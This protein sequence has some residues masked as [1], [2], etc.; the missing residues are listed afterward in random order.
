MLKKCVMLILVL[1]VVSACATVPT[2]PSVMVLPAVGKPFDQF[3]LD[4]MVCRQYA[5]QQVG[6]APGQAAAQSAVNTAVLGTA[7]GAAAGAAIGAATGHPGVGAAVGAGGGLLTGTA[8]GAQA[9]A[10]SSGAL[11]ER[12][13]ISYVQCMY[14]KGDQVPGVAPAP[15]PSIPPPP[16]PPS[17][18]QH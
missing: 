3:Q 18:T 12:F 13:D 16:P 10:V 6:V 7:I 4:D 1:G 17:P 15:S 11:Q 2:G 8:A 14:A 5:Q 9:G